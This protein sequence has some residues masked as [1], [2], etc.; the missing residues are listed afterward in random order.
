MNW[1]CKCA[2]RAVDVATCFMFVIIGA[3]LMTIWCEA[4]SDHD[5]GKKDHVPHTHIH[6]PTDGTHHKHH[7]VEARHRQCVEV[8]EILEEAVDDGLLSREDAR[9]IAGNCYSHYV[10]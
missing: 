10:K 8:N 7:T 6:G 9:H 3:G 2:I 4:N 1:K 5:H